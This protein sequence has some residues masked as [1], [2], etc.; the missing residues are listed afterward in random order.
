VRD[1]VEKALEAVEAILAQQRELEA[2]RGKEIVKEFFDRYDLNRLGFSR[3]SFSYELAQRAKPRQRLQS[4]IAQPVRQIQRYVPPEL[5]TILEG[6][7]ALL[8]EEGAK[9]QAE[10]ARTSAV[11][12]RAAWETGEEDGVNREQFRATL[13]HVARQLRDQGSN[14]ASISLLRAAV[15]LGLG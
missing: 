14:E 6:A 8:N 2:F 4:L 1:I 13:I 12:A 5:T 11:V 7:V 10:E 9:S 15:Q 3:R